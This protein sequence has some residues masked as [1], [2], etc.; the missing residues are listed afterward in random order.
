MHYTG[1]DRRKPVDAEEEIK[2]FLLQSTDPIMKG[3]ALIL[4]KVSDA[5]DLN[6]EITHAVRSELKDHMEE[7]MREISSQ[8]GGVKVGLWAL[9]IIQV[10]V[11][12]VMGLL[13]HISN[14]KFADIAQLKYDMIQ[15]Q[16]FAA[17][18]KMH[19]QQEE[20]AKN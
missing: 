15:M 17:E 20:K 9:G 19:H 5:V 14:E 12:I 1:E 6:T 16:V 3:I 2:G 10:L 4:L 13:V 11:G 18:H 8:R 7:E